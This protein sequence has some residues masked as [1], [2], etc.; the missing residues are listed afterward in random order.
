[1][2]DGVKPEDRPLPRSP[3]A[4]RAVLGGLM[5]DPDQVPAISETLSPA[6]FHREQHQRLF[7]LMVEMSGKGE[8]VEMPAV[9]GEM[10]KRKL[11][12]AMGGIAYVSALP[13]NV[14]STENLGYYAKIIRTHAVTRR[15]VEDAQRIITE[16]LSGAHELPALMELAEGT[17]GRLAGDT[18]SA[19]WSRLSALVPPE[20]ARLQ[21]LSEHPGEVTGMS[22][23]FTELDRLLAGLQRT[24]LLVLAARPSM[25][26]AQP[27]TAKILTPTGWTTMG[28]LKVG[29][30]VVG[31]DGHP[32]RV[33]GVYPQGFRPVFKVR[34]TDGAE[35]MCCD[36]HLWLTQTRLEL[37]RG[38]PASV[39]S[40]AEIR[41]SLR[42]E[43]GGR[44]NHRTPT[45][46]PVAFAPSGETPISPYLLG[47]ILGDGSLTKSVLFHNP[48]PDLWVA[49]ERHIPEGDAVR[50]MPGGVGCAVTKE[51]RG[52]GR[53]RTWQ[54]IERLG[55]A[56]CDSFAKF[57]PPAYLR[58]SIET[59]I[60]LL[61]GLCDTDG[62]VCDSGQ[63]IEYSTSS[64][65]LARDVRELVW[66]LGG[67]ATDT[68]RQTFYTYKGERLS[69]APSHRLRLTLPEHIIPVASVKNLAKWRK[70]A[71]DKRHRSFD[72]VEPAG[73]AECQCI[74]VEATDHQYVT[75]DFIVTHNTA[76][77][78]NIARNV[79]GTPL[80]TP[81]SGVGIFSLEMT[82]E[83]LVTRL[84]CSEAKVD[85][86][87]LRTG[88]LS[89]GEDWPALAAASER[90]YRLPIYIDDT[91]GLTPAQ[92]RA[93][94]RRL[95]AQDPTLGLIVVDY[96][97]L[98][99]GDPKASSEQ[100]VS[101][102]SRALKA[103]A[104]EL[105]VAI[106]AL[107]Q[108][109]RQVE[110]RNPKIPQLSDL[111]DSGAIEQDA[112]VVMLIYRDDYY[113]KES[114]KRGEAEVIIAKQRNGPLGSADLAFHGRWTRFED[115]DRP[116]AGFSG[117]QV[118]FG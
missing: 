103:L 2:G 6:D 27:M 92:L 13:D 62:S 29:D 117:E 118:V 109:S 97:G 64:D 47:L 106:I 79:A 75:D 111:R 74:M 16:A 5:L 57:I 10:V 95:K 52:P 56:G 54:A 90:L 102:A 18:V 23:G 1:V 44:L 7:T 66:S 11:E 35:T 80:G 107:A 116:P 38:A 86:G 9:V 96:I 46:Q 65:R 89:A 83:Q 48:E 49:V 114:T 39:K 17:L 78:V 41:A 45:V 81:L 77:A 82:R 59:R 53:S 87:R 70:G 25:G 61:Q 71:H 101:A 76:L 28:S 40:L 91:P 4:E 14:P 19:G 73:E 55:L 113:N 98:M 108:L 12:E 88:R 3:E 26:K 58:G 30:L 42:W 93:R 85:A 34:M 110:N 21:A 115:L 15:L 51:R 22:T 24:D 60:A 37:R 8:P 99:G 72:T 94:A 105:D 36:E 67:T 63:L 43:G 50:L 104:K 32:T 100:R 112:D 69:G 68:V 84:L 31:S 33:L 20:F